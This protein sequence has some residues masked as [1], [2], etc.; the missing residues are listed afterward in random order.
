VIVGGKYSEKPFGNRPGLF[1]T[2][3]VGHGLAAAGLRWRKLN[4]DA[5]LPE[6]AERGK[7]DPRVKLIDV[8]RDEES[9]SGHLLL[10]KERHT[11]RSAMRAV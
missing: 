2:A 5:E 3:G 1:G 8:A 6:Q 4:I 10:A 11:M 9:D 7:A